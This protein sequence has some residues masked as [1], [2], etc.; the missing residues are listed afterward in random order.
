MPTIASPPQIREDFD[1]IADLSPERPTPGPHEGWLLANLPAHRETLLEVG[2]G[3]GNLSRR[4]ANV[5]AKIVAIDFSPGMI[6]EARRRT[7]PDLPIDYVCTDM[8]DWLAANPDTYDC[9]V[10]VATLHHVDLAAALL[11]MSRSLKTGGRLLVLDLYDRR[12][13]RN[14]LLNGLAWPVAIARE[15]LLN[16]GMMPWQLRRAYWR[17]GRNETYL[18]L[19]DVER[20]VHTQLPGAEVRGHLL[21]RYSISWNKP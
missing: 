8:F 15:L 7:G 13:W 21:W 17:H 5:F 10:S 9:I 3:V 18:S 14:V 11:A 19:P 20:V 2:C 12:G 16:R 4:L 6:A 1:V